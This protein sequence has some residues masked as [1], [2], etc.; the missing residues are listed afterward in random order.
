MTPPRPPET[1]VVF[2]RTAGGAEPVRDWLKTLPVEDRHR[3]GRDLAIVQFGWPVRLPICRALS[4]GLWEL[5]SSLPSLRIAR[6][7]FFFHEG[8]IGVV[9]GF[10]KKT[11]KTPAGDLEL[12]RKRMSE[13]TK[14]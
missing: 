6:I 13:M 4:A 7:L 14:G 9:H 10:I 12:A 3:I 2:Y 8:R 1:P 5:R 11:Q